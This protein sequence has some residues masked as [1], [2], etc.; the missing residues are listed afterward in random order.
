MMTQSGWGGELPPKEDKDPLWR[1]GAVFTQA[2][3]EQLI[4]DERVPEDRRVPYAVLFQ[5]RGVGS[6][7][8]YGHSRV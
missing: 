5:L 1:A 4:G 8:G 7:F 2:E 6:R 3:V